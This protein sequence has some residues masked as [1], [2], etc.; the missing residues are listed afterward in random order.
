MTVRIRRLFWQFAAVSPL[1][2]S[3]A[4]AQRLPPGPRL[5]EGQ[6]LVYRL[7]TSG[8]RSTR[9]SSR[10]TSPQ[11]PAAE[12]LNAFCLLQ[13]SVAQAG[14]DGFRLKT[15]LSDKVA[16]KNQNDAVDAGNPASPDKL[17]EV[18]IGAGG[19]AS[20]IKGL[21]QLTPAQRHAWNAW[22]GRF[23]A[24]MTFPQPGVRPGQRWKTSED[25]TS[26]SPIARLS[27]ESRYEY[28]KWEPCTSRDNPAASARGPGRQLAP[29][30]CAVIL[31]HAALRQKSPPGN[32]TPDDYRL[33]GLTTE[34]TA[35]GSNMTVLYLSTDT[36]ILVRATEDA[37]QSMDATVALRDGTNQVR[38]L[39]SAKSRLRVE[40][41][42]DTPQDVR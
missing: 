31:V 2:V 37:E 6:T 8:S 7:E 36:G 10:V 24:A 21:E 17:V 3:S 35:T 15:Y 20:D 38:Y 34:G 29:D 42:P 9:V 16:A 27:W 5:Y 4:G 28:A 14:T 26:P 1:W 18:S 11:S 13:V 19:S 22:L 30:G 23:T 39:I 40:L 41:L 33:R 25:E 32:A 12:D